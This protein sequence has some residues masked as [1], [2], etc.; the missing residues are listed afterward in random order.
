M[1]S[2]STRYGGRRTKSRAQAMVEFGLVLPILLLIMYGLI[3]S[4]RLL[5][6]Y[7]SVVSAARQAVRYGSVTGDNGSGTPYYRD[8]PGIR[9]A[10]KRLGFLQG[11]NDS[12]I[13]ISYDTG[14][15]GTSIGDNSCNVTAGHPVNGDRIGV[16]VSTDYSPIVPLVPF[17]PFTITSSGVRTLL[18]GSYVF[19]DSPGVVLPPGS[20]GDFTM[21]KESTPTSFGDLGENITYTYTLTNL[22]ST[23]ITSLNLTDSLGI[24]VSCP[25][26]S[27]PAS[28]VIQCTASYTITQADIDAG[29]VSNTATATGVANGTPVLAQ[30]SLTI[31]FIPQPQLTLSKHGEPPE[32][33]AR[34]NNIVYTFT[35]LNSG[36]VVLTSPYTIADSVLDSWNCTGATSPLAINAS[37][38]CTGT[39]A[40]SNS[41]INATYVDNS[42]TATA[43]Y[44]SYT[45]TSN[46]A[47]AQTLV[48]KLLLTINASPPS[49]ST[50]GE[51]ITYTYVLKNRTASSMSNLK[52]TDSRGAG[53]YA[54][55]G[56]LAAGAQATCTRNYT[57]YTQTDMNAGLVLNQGTASAQGGI[58]S[59]SATNTVGVTQTIKLTLTK[60]ASPTTALTAGTVITYGYSFKN[61]GNV[62]LTEPYAVADDKITGI[63]CSGATGTLAPGGTK[64][65]A[66]A[67]HSVTVGDIAAGSIVN[68]ATVS[69]MFG[70][71]TVPSSPVSKTV[72]TFAGAR[73]GL[74]KS[75]SELY[76]TGTGQTLTYTYK[77]INTGGVVLNPP[78]S[79][80]DSKI[81][82]V[83]CSAVNSPGTPI[84]VGGFVSCTATYGVS[85]DDNTL[86]SITNSA[87]ATANGGALVSSNPN[88]TVLTV[89]KF[90]CTSTTLKHTD[91]TPIPTGNDITWTIVNNTGIAVHIA[92]IT[93]S[94]S[95]A[96][97]SLT[98]VQ[99][100]GSTIWNGPTNS[101]NGGFTVPGGPWMLDT[102]NTNMR[103]L[104]SA[105]ASGVRIVLTF[106][107]DCPVVDSN[108][109]PS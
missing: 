81:P 44:G 70:T 60:T 3:E 77:L 52:V 63:N 86:G 46:V 38:T 96:P 56:S 99:L 37:T 49:V 106:S 75:A 28:G 51:T 78:Y 67:T 55:L 10:A 87:S 13:L 102:G 25:G 20:S 15:G 22:G 4:G 59:N 95:S 17:G 62:D 19:I 53:N 50:L 72:I 89:S 54:C 8:C 31:N 11:F 42:A 24:A 83:D 29:S 104:F 76:F 84:P 68:T 33:I 74:Q 71:Q 9:T 61:E 36:N 98:Q 18:V 101:S 43:L 65:C 57:A 12:D 16:Q 1:Q 69:A 108:V 82:A 34:G 14:P 23:A 21:Q 6:M 40:L 97:P 66:N 32:F 103:L 45:V 48:P 73:L 92:S 41:D 64:S 85:S 88:P 39:H 26:T 94:W 47:T 79:V 58:N 91:P 105:P 100:D 5:F 30:A 80:T 27:I 93:I 107:E 90:I 7:A 35:L 2:R 109:V